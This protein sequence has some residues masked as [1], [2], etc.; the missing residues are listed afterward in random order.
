M[1]AVIID[2]RQDSH[3]LINSLITEKYPE[4]ELQEGAY[5]VDQGIE[6]IEKYRPDIVFLDIMMP[7][8]KGGKIIEAGFQVLTY[9]D[10]APN[11]QVIFITGEEDKMLKAIRFG[12]QDYVLKPFDEDDLDRVIQRAL[13]CY[14]FKEIDEQLK[15][16]AEK[17]IN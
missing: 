14:G 13:Q 5:Y 9:F 8:E 7:K 1:K 11:F 17:R 3:D 15:I 4:I 2:D 6:H 12:G 10:L 16:M